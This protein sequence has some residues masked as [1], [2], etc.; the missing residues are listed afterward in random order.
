MFDH[1]QHGNFATMKSARTLAWLL[2]AAPLLAQA[3]SF[4]VKPIRLILSISGAGDLTA[5]ALGERMGQALGQPIVVEVQSGAGGAQGA[6]A[7]AR[8]APDG[9]T[10]L[11]SS[12]S[13]MIMRPFLV[14]EMPY[15]TLRDFVPISRVGE[16]IAAIFVD[17]NFPATSFREVIEYARRNP[18]K[19]SYSTTGIGTTHHLSGHM[20]GEMNNM[21]WVHVPYKSGPQAVQ[22]WVAGRTPVSIG[23][24]GTFT[25]MVQAG[26]VRVVAI[27]NNERFSEMPAVP[28]VGEVLP[29][30]D[31]PAGWMAYFGPVAMPQPV[32]KRIEAEIIKA[33]NEPAIK[34]KLLGAGIVVDT[35]GS[36]SFLASIKRE[37][38]ATARIV[39]SA[40]IQPE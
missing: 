2:A 8:A 32:V 12:T 1:L 26:K 15:D 13:A 34:A 23:P 24:L 18:G 35:L 7:V 16:A 31:R 28:T 3:Q 37:I 17:A 38:A 6:A 20:I 5:R 22:D 30:Y 10:L 9:H 21:N 36:E 29:G 40:G 11:F 14:K 25:G 39:K 4:P 27:N 33:G 19:V